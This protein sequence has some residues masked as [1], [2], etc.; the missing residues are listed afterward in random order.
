[1]AS[2]ENSQT[3]HQQLPP[4]ERQ[5]QDVLKGTLLAMLL[6][7]VLNLLIWFVARALNYELLI[8]PG[9]NAEELV[10]LPWIAVV[11]ITVV[12]ALFAGGVL[13]L[14]DRFVSHPYLVF[15]IV[16]MLGVTI[17]V[18]RLLSAPIPTGPKAVLALMQIVGALVISTTLVAVTRI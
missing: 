17:L 10:A 9:L 18:I 3:H 16:A 5:T 11:A 6:A 15:Y 1:M 7:T 8:S 4:V 13:R 14:L 2:S 12:A